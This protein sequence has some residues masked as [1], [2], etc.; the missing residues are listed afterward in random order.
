MTEFHS[1]SLGLA[2]WLAYQGHSCSVVL[3]EKDLSKALFKFER[4]DAGRLDGHIVDYES[5]TVSIS[6]KRFKQVE[7]DLKRRMFALLDAQKRVG[8]R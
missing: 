1:E 5:N 7:A 8:Q 4:D 2:A 3:S 6:P